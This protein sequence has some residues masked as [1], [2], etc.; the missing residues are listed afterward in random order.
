[1]L[2]NKGHE[3]GRMIV[4]ALLAT[5]MVAQ[6]GGCGFAER[7]L[8]PDEPLVEPT[9]GATEKGDIAYTGDA[10]ETMSCEVAPDGY[11]EEPIAFNTEE[12]NRLQEQGFISAASYCNLR[13]ML[14][15]G[16]RA[17]E[18][19][20]GAVRIEEMLNYFHYDYATG[21]GDNLFG[22]T[23]HVGDCPWN[24]ETKLVTIGFATAPE[25][26]S[27]RDAGA[28]LV[29]LIDTSG[30]M[31][32]ADKL[33]LLKDAFD[34]L[35]DQLGPNDRV[36]IVTY[37]GSEE[38]V[39]E[40]ARGDQKREITRA[41][42]R[43][44]A[45]GSTNGEAGLK[46]A[47]EVAEHNFIKGGVNRI[48]MASDGDLNVGMTSESDLHDYVDKQRETGVYLSVLGFGTGNYKD[49][50][51]ETLADHGNGN[52]H[53]IDCIEEAE[54]V[55]GEDLTANLVPLADDTKVQVEFN[56]AQVKGYRLIGY[57]NRAMADEDFK[58]DKKDAGD[59]GPG[60]QFTVAYEVAL[61]DSK[62]EVSE[63]ELKYGEKATGDVKS[64]EWLCVTIRYQPV[65]GHEAREQQQTVGKRDL[66]SNPGEDWSF[67]AAVIE[68]G[69]LLRDSEYAGS[70]DR[71]QIEDLL[72]DAGKGEDREGFAD[73]VDLALE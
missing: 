68:L 44:E 50:K 54:R 28:N 47:Y 12:Y 1:M 7:R 52:Y 69:M 33:G 4:A 9:S 70:A 56:P 32:S 73:L 51:M 26:Q 53:Y 15:S 60:A 14:R 5:S 71:R 63:T 6:L 64:D 67:Q 25:A 45:H 24:R 27:V 21:A 35:V 17:G 20:A 16:M 23:V 62:Q 22:T 37:A 18:I 59:V 31:Q 55:L 58:N 19:D 30:S 36:S 61:A 48:V 8:T 42:R 72:K 34:T 13:R 2:W 43:L 10:Y 3:C 66:T 49:N 11:I 65:G 57:E 41:I 38:V 39:L 40:G 29:F 46:M